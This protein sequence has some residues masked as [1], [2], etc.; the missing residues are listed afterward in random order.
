MKTKEELLKMT[1]NEL[2]EEAKSLKLKGYS[3][4]N[5]D[6]LARAISI[7]YLAQKAKETENV[8]YTDQ[9]EHPIKV[10]DRVFVRINNKMFPGTIS[11]LKVIEKDQYAHVL[12]DGADKTK[13]FHTGDVKFIANENIL[14]PDE[15]Q[16][17]GTPVEDHPTKAEDNNIQHEESDTET[18]ENAATTD[19][20]V[21]EDTAPEKPATKKAKKQFAEPVTPD[22]CGFSKGDEVTFTVA[23]NSKKA[24][25]KEL[26]G[27]VTSFKTGNGKTFLVI[28]VEDHGIFLKESSKCIK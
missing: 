23:L 26:T 11:S 19:A 8:E 25:G 1:A 2:K 20:P 14:A 18:S 15:E 27:E 7:A 6:A 22:A 9:D 10:T 4:M 3:D 21:V 16:P 12:L 28:K 24:A 17:A 5:K 13:M